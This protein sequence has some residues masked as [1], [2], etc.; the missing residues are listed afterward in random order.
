MR[1]QQLTVL[2]K[3]MYKNIYIYVYNVGVLFQY[4]FA[5]NG[6]IYHDFVWAKPRFVANI[7]WSLGLVKS[8]Y[9]VEDFEELEKTLLG[10]AVTLIDTLIEQGIMTRQFRKKKEKQV[11]DIQADILD[12]SGKPCTWRAIETKQG[13][14]YECL[15]HG[16]MVKMEDDKKPE[17]DII[18][19]FVPEEVTA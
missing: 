11:A 19:P 14:Y 17:H 18:S 6:E 5:I 9:T 7:K 2:R 10:G 15:T 4:V 1:T 13:F 12:R 16:Q 8:P 3:M